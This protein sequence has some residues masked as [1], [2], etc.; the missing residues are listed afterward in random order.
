MRLSSPSPWEEHPAIIIN[1]LAIILESGRAAVTRADGTMGG[2][3][4]RRAAQFRFAAS[5]GSEL[6]ATIHSI[7]GAGIGLARVPHDC[8]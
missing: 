3:G 1:N 5:N 4:N 7:I 6:Q 2:V 8:R